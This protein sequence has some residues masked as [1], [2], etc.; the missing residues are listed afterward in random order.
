VKLVGQG[1]EALALFV[2]PF[3]ADELHGVV[4]S[5]IREHA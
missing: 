2:Q 1:A 3:A 5:A 4:E